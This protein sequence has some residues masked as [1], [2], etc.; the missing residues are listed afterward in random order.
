MPGPLRGLHRRF[1]YNPPIVTSARHFLSPAEAAS[2][3]E[4]IAGIEAR[5]GT[6]IVTA[7][8]ARSD[9]YVEL[10]WK[11]FAL[12]VSMAA[13]ALVGA[14]ALS[15][16]WTTAVTPLLDAAVILCTGAAAALLA[17]F[18]PPFARLFL[19]ASRRD[20]ELRVHAES[21]FLRHG[22]FS[23]RERSAVL[24]LISLF[25][26][27][28]EILADTG[29]H[30]RISEREWQRVVA[31]MTPHLR[32]KRLLQALRHGLTATGDLLASTNMRTPDSMSDELPNA[33][34]EEPG[35]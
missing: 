12:G 15:P 18:V 24:I 3:D 27:R 17:V 26:R 23:T 7:V 31:S 28:V 20:L 29:L 32:E 33:P 10:P 25:E 5:T 9:A 13:F 4:Q 11:A 19:R 1:G 8:V 22:L 16:Q 30:D 21:L 35:S 6:Q 14:N 2:V 34:I